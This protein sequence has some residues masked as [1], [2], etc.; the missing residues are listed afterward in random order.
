MVGVYLGWFVF[1]GR[2]TLLDLAV[3]VTF[4]LGTVAGVET[5]I[6]ALS[7]G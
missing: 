4:I 7:R 3:V 6:Q 2:S 5:L 1:F